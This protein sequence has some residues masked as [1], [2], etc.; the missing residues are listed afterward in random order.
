[1]HKNPT[2]FRLLK[3]HLNCFTILTQNQK[4][5]VLL[6][7]KEHYVE[8]LVLHNSTIKGVKKNEKNI[9]IYRII[10]SSY[11]IL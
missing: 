3:K 7:P 5:L 6:F 4:N 10:L 8:L 1:M 11:Y 9:F 2:V